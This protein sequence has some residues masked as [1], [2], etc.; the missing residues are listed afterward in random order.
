MKKTKFLTIVLAI[1]MLAAMIQIAA[2]A[3]YNSSNPPIIK[4]VSFYAGVDEVFEVPQSGSYVSAKVYLKNTTAQTVTN[5]TSF[6]FIMK[7]GSEIY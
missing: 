5:I 4:N 3:A 7:E 1:A 6:D 2:F